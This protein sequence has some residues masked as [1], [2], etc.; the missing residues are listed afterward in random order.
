MRARRSLSRPKSAFRRLGPAW[1]VGLVALFIMLLTVLTA[2]SFWYR[3]GTRVERELAE[4]GEIVVDAV[5][6]GISAAQGRLVATSAL[7]RASEKV[8]RSEFR[9][10]VDDV[11]LS[12][13]MG[14]LGY[15]VLLEDGE[16]DQFVEVMARDVLGFEIFERTSSGKRAPVGDRAVY[17][18]IQWFEPAEAL[19]GPH[20]LDEGSEP[21]RLAALEWA[22]QTEMMA[23]TPLLRLPDE[24][25]EDGFVLYQP[26]L[27]PRSGDVIGFTT[28]PM[29]L[30]ELV[31]AYLPDSVTE[32]MT[33]LV[34]DVSS[35]A[36]SLSDDLAMNIELGGRIWEVTVAARPGSS[37]TD[38][39]VT[40]FVLIAGLVLTVSCGVAARLLYRR[41]ESN[42]ELEHLRDLTQAKDRFLASVSHELRTPLTGVLGFAELLRD[43]D[44]HVPP[45]ER[46]QMLRAVAEQALDLGHIIEDL[47]VGA[48]AE[49]DQL[50][51]TKVPVLP[52]A[53]V[54][55]VIEAYGPEVGA[56][57]KVI[58]ALPTDLRAMGDPGRVRQILR[59]LINNACRYGGPR[60]EVM[61]DAVDNTIRLEVADNGPP[62]PPDLQQRIFEPYQ[63]AHPGGSQPDSVG[64]GLSIARTLARLMGGDVT[65]ARRTSWNVFELSLPSSSDHVQSAAALSTTHRRESRV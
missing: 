27:D 65:Y 37:L 25:D 19:G 7:I 22:K 36:P 64:I 54:A 61:I 57:V 49:L 52:R 48:R 34:T 53:Q 4:G 60:I 31:T 11:G 2:L 42:R 44:S 41:S 59:N 20:G 26:V 18:P 40:I 63:R 17:Y 23:V 56:R 10:F 16:L 33:W 9:S 39:S 35:A 30:S 8:S 14:G 62:I 6:T 55:Q 28:A 1:A 21:R 46:Q 45:A 12:E 13:G 29:D 24:D 58:D 50:T 47:L 3:A 51:I 38:N 15:L 43:N 32:S 5:N